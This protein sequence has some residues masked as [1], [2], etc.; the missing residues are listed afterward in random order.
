MLFHS[1]IFLGLYL[2]AVVLAYYALAPWRRARAW[3]LIAASLLFYG[4]WDPRAV[5]LLVS[6]ILANWVIAGI[7]VR[8]PQDWLTRCLIPSGLVINLALLGIFKYADLAADTAAWIGGWAREP[9]D[10]VLPLAISFFTFQQISYLVDL[11]R[12]KAPR[13]DLRDYALFIAFFPQLIAGP[14]VRHHEI[15]SQFALDPRRPG[16]AERCARGLALFAMGLA[17][18]VVLA[19]ELAKLAKPLL[20]PELGSRA[21]GLL[22]AWTCL[23]AY[24]FQLYFDFSA[25]S[26]MALGLA[27]LF[28]FTL[29][30]NFNAP[31]GACSIL[32]FWR[33]WHMTL[34]RFFRDYVYRP[35]GLALPG[36]GRK[37]AATLI[38][39]TLVGL[40][41][42]ASWSFALFGLLH[43]LALLVNQQARGVAR[44]LPPLLGWFLCFHFVVL[45]LTLFSTQSVPTSLHLLAAMAG[46]SGLGASQ[47]DP[48]QLCLLA[49]AAALAILGP[50]SQSMALE[51]LYP[52]WRLALPTAAVLVY[53]L[54]KAGGSS[55]QFIYFQF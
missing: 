7:F 10:L 36:A 52:T 12:N 11:K 49:A 2:P 9:W 53:G 18:K 19:D 42:G 24:A 1:A 34:T 38:T 22:E 17:K 3:V 30:I 27:L 45:T 23:Y 43:G 21:I 13:Y 40:W 41:H 31:Y 6:S 20:D 50:T 39:M 48:L 14:I 35:I 16:W 29:P 25:Y 46:G 47:G 8:R 28:G 54:F 5:P 4:Y 33:R 55:P 51:R 44:R 37:I 32:D 26:D 15:I